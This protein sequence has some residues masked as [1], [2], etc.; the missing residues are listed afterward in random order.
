MYVANAFMLQVLSLA[1]ARSESEY[2]GSPRMCAE[3][4][5]GAGGPHEHAHQYTRHAAGG[6]P[7]HAGVAACVACRS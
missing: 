4:E 2:G 1:G 3:S 7:P 6:G 5:E